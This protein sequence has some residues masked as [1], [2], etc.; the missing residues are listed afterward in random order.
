[1]ARENEISGGVKQSIVRIVG[2]AE[3]EI[4]GGEKRRNIGI[5]EQ[6]GRREAVGFVSVD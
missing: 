4:G 3:T 5:V 6:Q 1:M 2:G